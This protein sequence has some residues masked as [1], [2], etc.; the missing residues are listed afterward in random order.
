MLFLGTFMGCDEYCIPCAPTSCPDITRVELGNGKY[1]KL[2]ATK[3]TEDNPSPDFPED[4]DF[5]TL[6]YARYDMSSSNAGNVNWTLDN[7][8][9]VLVKRRETGTFN[10]MTIKVQEVSGR[11]DFKIAGTDH[12]NAAKTEYEYAVV[13]SFYGMEGNYDTAKIY[14]DFNAIY[15][16][17]ANGIAHTQ[18]GDGYLDMTN[19][20]PS[21]Y[22][23]TLHGRY[24]TVVRNSQA[25]Y[26]TG[27][28]SGSFFEFDDAAGDY[29]T[30]DKSITKLQNSV[31]TLLSDGTPKLIK[32]FD[33]R[34][35]LAN[36]DSEISNNAD[37]N[38]KNR[39]ISFTFT[40]TGNADSAEDLYYSGLSDITEEWW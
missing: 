21:A 1:E 23:T 10:W 9:H 39:V 18:F 13:P 34:N 19:N 28:F 15:I 16:I 27:S 17:G 12:T 24:P 6:M 35:I 33:G 32:H 37:G 25:N 31:I 14:S 29:I 20:A 30:E 11:D 5:N 2:Y 8:S 22:I 36:I 40:E 38:Y 26:K 4:W 7:I 3:T